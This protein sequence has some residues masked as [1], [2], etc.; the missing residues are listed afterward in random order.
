[1]YLLPSFIYIHRSTKA[2]LGQFDERPS[3]TT[4][5]VKSGMILRTLNQPLDLAWRIC[6]VVCHHHLV[7]P[8]MMYSSV[9]S[10][11]LDIIDILPSPNPNPKDGN[12]QGKLASNIECMSR[13]IVIMVR[14][15]IPV[16]NLPSGMIGTFCIRPSALCWTLIWIRMKFKLSFVDMEFD[17]LIMV[18]SLHTKIEYLTL[19]SRAV[20]RQ[21]TFELFGT[22]GTTVLSFAVPRRAKPRQAFCSAVA[23]VQA[24]T[25]KATQPQLSSEIA[26]PPESAR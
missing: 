15:F 7:H 22:C 3:A 2:A 9:H 6:N 4:Q 26:L 10:R 5:V 18:L 23:F 1:M 21:R 19:T 24:C 11:C 25:L 14:M 20:L 8:S 17:F 13:Y 12:A 16:R